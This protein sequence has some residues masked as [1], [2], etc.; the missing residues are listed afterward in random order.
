ML[1]QGTITIPKNTTVDAPLEQKL[2]I[3]KGIISKFMVRPRAGHAGLAHLLI[4]HHE[5]QIAPSTRNMDLHGD[6]FPI[7]WDDYFECYQPP[8]ELKL[9]GWNE[10]DTYSH[11][12]DVYVAVLPRKAIVITALSD[13]L[14]NFLS[15]IASLF[16]MFFPRAIPIDEEEGNEGSS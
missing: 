12:F 3:A 8:Y 4:I 5:N 9:I 10:D 11:A 14:Q 16:G 2:V 13:L 1:F 15:T 6:S 7:D